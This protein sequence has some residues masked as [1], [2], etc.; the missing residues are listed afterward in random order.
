MGHVSHGSYGI[1]SQKHPR[2]SA[3][4]VPE[5]VRAQQSAAKKALFQILLK[6]L[7]GGVVSTRQE[8]PPR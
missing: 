5:M 8:S 7:G 4:L 6:G 1:R 2:I 3:D